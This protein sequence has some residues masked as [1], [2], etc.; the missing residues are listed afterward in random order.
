MIVNGFV[1]VVITTIEK[2]FDL[3]STET[4]IIA[5]F[6]DISAVLCLI[7]VSYLGGFGRKPRWVATG[8]FLVGL[9]SLLFGLPHFMTGLYHYDSTTDSNQCLLKTG[10]EANSTLP[11][12]SP[13]QHTSTL[14]RFKYIFILAQ[15]LHGAGATPLCTLGI[16]YMDE[17]LKAKMTPVYTGQWLPFLLILL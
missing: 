8:V 11:M 14:N 6:F 4:G 2:R 15:M 12:C 13:E 3:A 10:K 5:S 9:G 1:S 16:T 7:P 17:N